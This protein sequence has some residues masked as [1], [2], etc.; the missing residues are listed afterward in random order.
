MYLNL[1]ITVSQ[2][3]I[4]ISMLLLPMLSVE[5]YVFVACQNII[6]NDM[7]LSFFQHFSISKDELQ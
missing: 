5:T 3:C 2:F 6:F 7:S 4:E 1:N